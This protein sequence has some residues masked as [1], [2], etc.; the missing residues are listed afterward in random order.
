MEWCGAALRS[1]LRFSVCVF[2]CGSETPRVKNNTIVTSVEPYPAIARTTALKL[3]AAKLE[4]PVRDAISINFLT[5]PN[6]K[7]EQ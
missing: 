2:C 5:K 7:I 4:I 3:A 1:I 6:Q